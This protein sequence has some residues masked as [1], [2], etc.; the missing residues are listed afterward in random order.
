MGTLDGRGQSCGTIHDKRIENKV[1]TDRNL[2]SGARGPEARR[3]GW[4]EVA[5]AARVMLM[6]S[7]PS[8]STPILHHVP[9][10]RGA[11]HPTRAST[12]RSSLL[13]TSL[14]LQPSDM[15]DRPPP[16]VVPRASRRARLPSFVRLPMLI[17]LNICLQTALWAG[18]EN[19]LSSELGAVSKVPQPNRDQ[20]GFGE[21]AE[22]LVRLV[23]KIALV[24]V[25]WELRYDCKTR[26][27]APRRAAPHSHPP[28][29]NSRVQTS[30]SA[31]LPP[32]S[33]SPS[34]SS[35]PPSTTS[36][37]SPQPPT[38][39]SK[40]SPSRSQPT[41]SAPSP[42]STTRPSPCATATSSTASRSNGQTRRSPSPCTLPSSTRRCRRAG[43]PSSSSTT[44][45]SRASR[46]RT[47]SS[48]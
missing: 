40:S 14:I 46:Q 20:D 43:S 16:T 32:S 37:S 6:T 39:P 28:C 36:P 4:E 5:R 38:S 8:T 25:A 11:L 23:S 44:S 48:P 1:K 22:P 26:R 27:A 35:S 19:V 33:T 31:R 13:S 45:T 29:T 3:D 47:T 17:I 10:L 2:D 42:T 12:P 18:A 9:A 30:T 21:L 7:E 15:A 24:A 41:S 34:P